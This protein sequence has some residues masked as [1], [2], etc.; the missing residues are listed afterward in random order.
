M[1][2]R[3]SLQWNRKKNAV[4]S[5]VH[6]FQIIFPGIRT[7]LPCDWPIQIFSS[8]RLKLYSHKHSNLHIRTLKLG[9]C[10][11]PFMYSSVISGMGWDILLRPPKAGWL[12]IFVG[13]SKLK[14]AGAG[15]LKPTWHTHIMQHYIL[16]FV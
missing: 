12:I 5:P 9:L 7:L 8:G 16:Y 15:S 6:I 2:S 14:R 11:P 3:Q 13:L 10:L 1:S 4:S